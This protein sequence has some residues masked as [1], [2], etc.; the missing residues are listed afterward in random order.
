MKQFSIIFSIL[1]RMII[2]YEKPIEL[3]LII[4]NKT[5]YTS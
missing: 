1:P 5:V 3:D 4:K 2:E